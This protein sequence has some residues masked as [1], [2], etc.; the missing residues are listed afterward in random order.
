[1]TAN[2]SSILVIKID[3]W[4]IWKLFKIIICWCSRRCQ[5]RNL[6]LHVVQESGERGAAKSAKRAK[7]LKLD[8]AE[9]EE[10]AVG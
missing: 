2:G 5:A 9:L 10:L 8:L 3:E 4:R 6:G 1:M 7:S